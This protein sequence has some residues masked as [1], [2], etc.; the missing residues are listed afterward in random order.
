MNDENNNAKGNK[1]S[2]AATTKH[3]HSE[4]TIAK[5]KNEA[6]DICV[7]FN[8]YSHIFVR[9]VRAS[10]RSESQKSLF[11]LEKCCESTCCV[12][13]KAPKF[14]Y[15][16]IDESSVNKTTNRKLSCTHAQPP[17]IVY[18]AP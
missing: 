13:E 14:V 16:F 4:I 1:L 12:K 7:H 3:H 18:I 5:H 6:K 11:L 10:E 17:R 9:T 2:E 8:L 15:I